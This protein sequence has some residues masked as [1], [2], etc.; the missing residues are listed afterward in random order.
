MTLEQSG[1]ATN[2]TVQITIAEAET[3]RTAGSKCTGGTPGPP[4]GGNYPVSVNGGSV[5]FRVPNNNGSSFSVPY[6]FDGTLSGGVIMGKMVFTAV[7]SSPGSGNPG[8]LV[9]QTGSTEIT[10]SLR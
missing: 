4:A 9:T 8:S 1:G 3:G 2:G 7:G 5:S 6:D 10:I